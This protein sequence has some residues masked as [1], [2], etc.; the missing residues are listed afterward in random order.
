MNIPDLKDRASHA[1][2]FIS[3]YGRSKYGMNETRSR[4][5]DLAREN[6]LTCKLEQVR[7]D[8]AT[9]ADVLHVKLGE[10]EFS[11]I[12]KVDPVVAE[13]QVSKDLAWARDFFETLKPMQEQCYAEA[14]SKGWHPNDAEP[15]SEK[16]VDQ[17][18]CRLMC[19]HE[20][21]SELWSAVRSA[22]FRDRCDK[23]EKM[24]AIGLPA[25]TCGE[26]EFAD[27]FIRLLDEAQTHGIDMSKAVPV[28]M[29]Y[30]RSRAHR[31]GGKKR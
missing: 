3:P 4:I 20:E 9:G 5:E 19:S 12:A 13:S 11:I 21:I 27:R 7:G 29:L 26:E 14:A 22:T 2:D 23:A 18:A 10:T 28:K 6:G 15:D 17:M 31:H 24:E 16:E 8:P 30:N 1:L 25:L